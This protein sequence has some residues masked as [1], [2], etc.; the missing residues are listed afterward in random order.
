M[1]LIYL[2]R[3]FQICL[4][5]WIIARKQEVTYL[6]TK[7]SAMCQTKSIYFILFFTTIYFDVNVI[8]LK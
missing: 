3:D 6:K 2:D 8:T 1:I 5:H 4:S 7:Q